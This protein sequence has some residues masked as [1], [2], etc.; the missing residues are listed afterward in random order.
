MPHLGQL[1]AKHEKEG[2]TVIAVAVRDDAAAVEDFVAKRSTAWNHPVAIDLE[3]GEDSGFMSRHWLE[4]SGREGIPWT[5]LVDREGRI[6]WIGH[7]MRVDGPL[8]AVLAGNFDPARQ[9]QVDAAFSE[10]D[11]KLGAA[12]R[13]NRW[14]EVLAVLDDMKQVDPVSTALNHSTTV[15]ALLQL[16]EKEAAVQFA[17]KAAKDAPAVVLALIANELL[18]APVGQDIDYDLAVR[19]CEQ[20]LHNG[21]SGNPLALGA[22]ARSYEGTGKTTEA[23][24]VWRQMLALDDPAIDKE[25]VRKRID[26][27]VR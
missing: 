12:L 13:E 22:L 18:K 4:G 14:R 11:L 15:K 27:W 23:V 20:A 21:E 17:R 25:N 9:Q 6:A 5:F 16:G 19:L 7:P 1:Q 26:E 3:E 24:R 8:A 10:L 2:L